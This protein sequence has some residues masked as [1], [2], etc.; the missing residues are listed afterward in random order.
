M[1]A[2]FRDLGG[3]QGNEAVMREPPRFSLVP[4]AATMRRLFTANGDTAA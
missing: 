4:S 1:Q 2:N 3:S